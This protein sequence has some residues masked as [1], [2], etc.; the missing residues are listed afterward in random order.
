MPLREQSGRVDEIGAAYCVKQ[1]RN[2]YVRGQQFR[3]IGSDVKLRLL[4]ALHNDGG[5]AIHAIEPGL[6]IVGRHG[7]QLSLGNGVGGEAVPDDGEAGESQTVSLDH[8]CRRQRSADFG[9]GRIH[10]LQRGHHV[11][12]PVEEQVDLG[13]AAAGNRTHLLQ[14][15]YAV[16]RLL[17]GPRDGHHHL[18]DG[19]HA[20][21]HADD[22]AGKVGGGKHR[23]GNGEGHVNA[24]QRQDHDQKDDGL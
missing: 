22:D 5:D 2:C 1:V 20:V 24:G 23:D 4:T 13:G 8:R 15:G 19:H 3:G 16:D 9:Q 14:A 7:P 10:E 12:M 18:V 21:V 17:D 11:H 6:Q